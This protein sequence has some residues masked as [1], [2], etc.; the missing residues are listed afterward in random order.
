[1]SD[2]H[3]NP[4]GAELVVRL[5]TDLH[6][7]AILDTG[8]VTTFG[9]G[10][11]ARFGALLAQAPVPYL[12]VP[13]NHDS[14]ANRLELGQVEGIRVL[15]GELVTVGGVRILGIADPTFTASNEVSTEEANA[16]KAAL[17]G[18]VRRQVEVE[19]PDLLAVHDPAQAVAATGIVPVV[20]AGHIH[21]RS[22]AVVDGTLVLTI[23]STGATGLGTFTVETARPYEA[24]VLRFSGD[25]LVAIDH[26][27]V[28]GIDG[29][30]TLER[31]LVEP[32]SLPSEGNAPASADATER[33]SASS[34][35]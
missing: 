34:A 10:V 13:G 31:R 17:T 20:V 33:R 24:E 21:K 7:D 30:F 9:L 12:L 14:M 27:S 18:D 4:L 1:V 23:G 26:L 32:R 29:G 19:D 6:V 22:E 25:E 28:S 11:E 2:L 5:A 15:D 35:G 16:R 8:D 3:V